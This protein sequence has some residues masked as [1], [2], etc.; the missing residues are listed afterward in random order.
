M[1]MRSSRLTTQDSLSRGIVCLNSFCAVPDVLQEELR[2]AYNQTNWLTLSNPVSSAK[3]IEPSCVQVG[4]VYLDP[5][6]LTHTSLLI[7][8]MQLP[9]ALE[10]GVEKSFWNFLIS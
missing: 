9:Q 10:A 3:Y 7:L 4:E 8:P 6:L 2:D 1:A 5:G